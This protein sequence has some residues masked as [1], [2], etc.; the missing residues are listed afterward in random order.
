MNDFSKKIIA[1]DDSKYTIASFRRAKR[2][3]KKPTKFD[4]Y[5]SESSAMEMI[6]AF[7]K[8]NCFPIF[9]VDLNIDD[10]NSGFRLLQKIRRKPSLR[11]APVII[12]SNSDDDEAI[13][14]SYKLGANAYHIKQGIGNF[15]KLLTELM[16]YWVTNAND[17]SV[18]HKKF[19]Q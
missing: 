1:I 7:I 5:Q 17:M 4:D 10:E 11:Y 9:F 2:K 14:K 8:S 15:E 18:I 13:R 6:D 12:I 16:D 19:R 3:H